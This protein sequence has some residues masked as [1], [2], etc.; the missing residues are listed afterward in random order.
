MLY[1]LV[2]G[3]MKDGV[4]I[5]SKMTSYQ[6][7]YSS[8]VKNLFTTEN[9][10]LKCKL[11]V[12]L[13]LEYCAPDRKCPGS[14]LV[15]DKTFSSRY[16]QFYQYS[17]GTW[18]SRRFRQKLFSTDPH[19]SWEGGEGLKCESNHGDLKDLKKEPCISKVLFQRRFT[20]FSVIKQ[21]S[22]SQAD[23]LIYP[24]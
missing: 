15:S 20:C 5:C 2:F 1:T 6:I 3:D 19:S 4:T 11:S 23:D 18:C 9:E 12:V 10:H 13:W 21:V 8:K 7:D 14:I 17:I 24:T 16:S 22:G